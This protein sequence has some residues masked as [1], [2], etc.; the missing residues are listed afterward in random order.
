M[1]APSTPTAAGKYASNRDIKKGQ[2]FIFLGGKPVAFATN[3]SLTINGEITDTTNKM[4]GDWESGFISK[5][6]FSISTEGLLTDKADTVSYGN[7]MK[8]INSMDPL[9]FWFGDVTKTGNEKEGYT[10]VKD[11]TKPYF[12]GAV[13]VE[14]LELTSEAGS[15]AKYSMSGKGTGE[16]EFVTP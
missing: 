8:A 9:D 3:A 13:N 10:F 12:M 14:S 1:G 7:F 6:S 16:L 11:E 5:K 15:L 4:S 2:L